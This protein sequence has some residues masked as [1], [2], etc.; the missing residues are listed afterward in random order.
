M[1]C[2]SE[3]TSHIRH[4]TALHF[5]DWSRVAML[6]F[7]EPDMGLLVRDRESSRMTEMAYSDGGTVCG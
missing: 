4:P 3:F 2:H 6:F 1:Q 7:G 5:S